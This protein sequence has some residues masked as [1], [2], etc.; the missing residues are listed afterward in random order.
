MPSFRESTKLFC[1]LILLHLKKKC[2]IVGISTTYFGSNDGDVFEN[3]V[4]PTII[5]DSEYRNILNMILSFD[6]TRLDGIEFGV[7]ISTPTG[8]NDIKIF[9]I[10]NDH[11]RLYVSDVNGKRSINTTLTNI[12]DSR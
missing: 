6:E 4:D 7:F 11:Y 8:N 5:S 10:S 1:L 12:I 2:K 9:P 3:T